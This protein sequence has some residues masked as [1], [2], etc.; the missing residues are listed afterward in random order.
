[1]HNQPELALTNLTRAIELSPKKHRK[2][3]KTD[4][5]FDSIRNDPRFQGLM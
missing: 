5:D 3:A 4:R 1:M 2:L